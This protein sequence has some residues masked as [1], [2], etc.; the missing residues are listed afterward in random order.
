MKTLLYLFTLITFT[1]ATAQTKKVTVPSSIENVTVFLQGAQITRTAATTIP[2]GTATLVF[3]GISPELE[4]KSIQVQ[5]KGA[6]TILSVSRERNYLNNQ[7]PQDEIKR[8]QEQLEVLEERLQREKNKESVFRQEE[9]MLKKNQDL[10]G[11]NTGLKTADLKEALDFQRNRLTEVLDQQL[12]IQANIRRLNDNIRQNMQ[13]RAALLE[14]KD[15]ST[16][17]LLVTV[18]SKESISGKLTLRYLVKNAGW[19]PTYELR[20][21]NISH[22]MELAY[23]A[24]VFQ[25][26]GE[27]WKNVKLS[28]SSG[29]PSES[30]QKPE[31]NAW[32]LRTF[33]SMQELT[34]ARYKSPLKDQGRATGR[35]MDG[36]GHPI[37]GA[38]IRIP[39]RTIGTTTN[40]KGE[41]SLQLP[42]GATSLDVT[43]I[44]YKDQ[45]VTLSNNFMNIVLQ[46]NVQAL[47][48]V[49]VVGYGKS[50]ETE[51][52]GRVAGVSSGIR[53]RG[54]NSAKQR[55]DIPLDVSASF[56]T[57]SVNFDIAVPYSIPSD[58]KPYAVSVSQTPVATSYQYHAAPKLDPAAYLVAGITAWEQLNLLDGEASIYFEGTYLGKSL[59]NLQTASDTLYVSLGKDKN[60]VINRKLQKEYSKN[61]F[62]A[63]NQTAVRNWEISVRN[64]KQ[65]PVRILV[66]DQVPMPAQSE[67]EVSR[68]SYSGATM[69]PVSQLVTWSLEIPVKQEKKMQLQYTVKYPKG[70]LVNL[71]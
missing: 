48:D 68:I 23:K 38:M 36:A 58:G 47:Q 27:D 59:L 37:I 56:H 34:Q 43:Y 49:V 54:V 66:E 46:E 18:S 5:G 30:G 35:V 42:T 57:T 62:L 19:Y 65:E 24:N 40:E 63:S 31:M 29:N 39:N 14:T 6:F 41:F 70:K 44:G 2:A 8:L 17:D 52:V 1:N 22:P 4:E 11:T 33:N 26:C 16:T 61:Q 67:V 3:P 15:T 28:L 9:E 71:D 60:I 53:I 64:N 12:A 51:V 55:E 10:R 50:I 25:Q 32:Y 21:E 13:Q 20:V 7:R 45:Q 69:D